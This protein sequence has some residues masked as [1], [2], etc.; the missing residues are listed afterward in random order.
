MKRQLGKKGPLVAPIGLGCMGMSGAYG[1]FDDKQ[2]I[3]TIERALEL[4]H[5]FLDTADYYLTG[6]NETLIGQAIKGKRE[7]AFLS[8]K[9]GQLVGPGP[10]GGTA[11]GPVTGRPEYI[12]NA[13]MY[14]LQRLKTDY[15]D[16]YTLARIDPDVPIEET[17]GAMADLVQKGVILN[18]GLSEASAESI[19]KAATVHPITALQ[20]EYSLWSRDIEEK[21][22]PTIRELGIGLVAYAPLS[23]G[24]LTGEYQ[25]PEDIKDSRAFIPR[26]QGENFYKN[27]EM[28]E[29]IKSLANEKGCTP[30]QLAIAW[31]L[32]QGEDII[33][34]PGT[35]QIKN[36][37]LNIA[38]EKVNL[39][40]E[41]LQSIE[42][43]MPLGSVSGTRYPE[44]F[45]STLN[46]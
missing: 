17:I 6:H 16:L 12:R 44:K 33:T 14:S 42:A 5:S 8:V 2:S 3:A 36:L 1:Q 4:E 26:F 41:D 19:R 37:E 35:K 28:V 45:M 7:K 30:S 38:A 43:I 11:P 29:K 24:F 18:I 34:I 15:I 31:V 40:T 25:K 23:R 10:N 32:A 39:T 46:R 21:V 22:L 20:I 27:L 9:T 13:V